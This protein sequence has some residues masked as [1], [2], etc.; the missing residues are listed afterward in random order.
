MFLF[1]LNHPHFRIPTTNPNPPHLLL[2][3]AVHLR[4]SPFSL[5]WHPP[6]LPLIITVTFKLLPI[7]RS[8][9]NLTAKPTSLV[10]PPPYRRNHRV[11]AINNLI[12]PPWTTAPHPQTISQITDPRSFATGKLRHTMTTSLQITHLFRQ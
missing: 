10:L 5:P 12:A 3:L 8:P 2:L 4:H 7:T 9:A 1:F 11:F 6:H